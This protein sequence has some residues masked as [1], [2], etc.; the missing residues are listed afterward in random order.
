MLLKNRQVSQG[1]LQLHRRQPGSRRAVPGGRGEGRAVRRRARF[2]ERIRAGGAGIAGVLHADRRRHRGR[3]GQRGRARST[4]A[5]YV[6]ERPLRADLAIVRAAVGDHF[7]NLRFYRTARN[8]NPLMAMAAE[9]DDRRGR[10]AGRPTARSIPT[11]F[12][13][14]GIFVQRIVHVP[15]HANVIEYRDRRATDRERSSRSSTM[16]W[17]REDM[18]RRAAT[19]IADGHDR[20]PGHRPADRGRQLHPAGRRRLAA[21][22]ERPARHGPV[23]DR[24]RGRPAAD[25]RRQAD[26][27]RAA[28]RQRRSIRRCRSR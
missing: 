18:V 10:P 25:Q 15:E 22:R 14:P 5:R 12:T 1:D 23:P 28:R 19:E 13:C 9:A 7:G 17:S 24:E 4:A 3:G 6:L 16:S 20:E 26:G 21:L 11:T 27:D 2:A 8:F